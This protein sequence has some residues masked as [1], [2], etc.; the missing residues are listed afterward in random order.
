MKPTLAAIL[1]NIQNGPSL[2]TLA[3]AMRMASA[4]AAFSLLVGMAIG[5]WLGH[6]YRLTKRH[7]GAEPHRQEPKGKARRGPPQTGILP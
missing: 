3:E 5:F 4:N 7:N 6:R 1:P 2:E